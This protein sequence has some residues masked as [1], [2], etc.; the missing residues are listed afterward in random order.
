L[1]KIRR[2]LPSKENFY[3]TLIE[4]HIEYEEYEHA[5]SI[6]NHFKCKSLGE[7][8]VLYLKID[9]LLADVFENLETCAFLH[10]I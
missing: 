1:G 8:S 10:A 5:V 2:T 6:W 7:Y 9:V 4:E 3:S